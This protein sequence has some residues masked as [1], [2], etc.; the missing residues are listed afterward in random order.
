MKHGLP[1]LRSVSLRRWKKSRHP[2]HQHIRARLDG[3]RPASPAITPLKLRLTDLMAQAPFL[4]P[5]H[6]PPDQ[7]VIVLEF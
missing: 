2:P 3:Y 6:E 7:F 5:I 1:P 4:E